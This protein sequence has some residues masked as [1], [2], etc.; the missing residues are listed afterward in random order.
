VIDTFEGKLIHT[1]TGLSEPQ[2]VAYVPDFDKLVVARFLLTSRYFTWPGG[3]HP[4]HISLAKRS[5]QAGKRQ[6]DQ[7]DKQVRGDL[8]ENKE[9]RHQMRSKTDAE[10]LPP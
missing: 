1:I 6:P 4:S 7:T 10:F 2:G 3:D 9:Q 5:K 8:D